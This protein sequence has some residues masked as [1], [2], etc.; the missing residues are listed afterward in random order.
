VNQQPRVPSEAPDV[1]L[2]SVAGLAT[3]AARLAAP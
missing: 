3:A 1:E 2:E